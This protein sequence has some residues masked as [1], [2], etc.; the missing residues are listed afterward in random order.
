M[1][2]PIFKSEFD[3]NFQN[4]STSDQILALERFSDFLFSGIDSSLFVLRGYA[5]TGKTSLMA[6]VVKSLEAMDIQCVLLAPTGRAAKVM[7]RFADHP[8]FTIHKAI[9][10]QKSLSLNPDFDL[11]FNSRKGAL[12]I[13]D[14]AS[15][16][17]DRPDD[18]RMQESLLQSL[19]TFVYGRDQ[20][21]RLVFVGDD[22]QLPPVGEDMSPA[23]SAQVMRSYAMRVYE[24]TLREVVRQADSGGILW[25]ATMLRKALDG[26]TLAGLPRIRFQEFADIKAVPGD[27][28]IDTLAECYDKSGMEETMVVCR[29]NRLANIY[30]NGIRSQILWRE[31]ELET[32][33]LVMV[34]KNNYYWT[35]KLRKE[36]EN[37][38]TKDALMDFMA[39]GDIA[40]VRRVRNVR[41]FYGFNFADCELAFPDYD[42]LEIE[43]TVLLDTLHAEAPALTQ[44]QN[45]KLFNNVMEDYMDI[46]SQQERLKQLRND[47]YYNA[48]Q[49]KYA[50]A[51][52]CHKAQGGQW[53]NIFIDQG[54]VPE[55]TSIKEY[56]RWLYTAMTRATNNLFLVNW[57]DSQTED[58]S[59]VSA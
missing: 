4:I 54:F 31:S 42:D 44:A 25:N 45:E 33:D 13:V 5:G 34:A 47:P 55:D 39:N 23:L 3:K 16:I 10:R 27:M 59:S 22:A 52:T 12:F 35:D 6:A 48:V 50:Y 41:S 36:N 26:D 58:T 1:I 57:K 7:S 15:M 24:T 19:M 30:N 49:L 18:G 43:A 29:S 37:N 2:N 32:G 28:L 46:P 56:Y 20:G 8:A 53:E 14:E 38:R 11:G 21:C 51:V 9:Y 17:S 40:V